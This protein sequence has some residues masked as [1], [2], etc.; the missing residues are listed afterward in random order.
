M[1]KIKI[2][3]ILDYDDRIMHGDDQEAKDWFINEVLLKETL[4]V[5]SNEI[6]DEVGSLNIE[7][8]SHD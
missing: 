2:I 8:I 7:S 6:G 3:A 4:I 1:G 5:H